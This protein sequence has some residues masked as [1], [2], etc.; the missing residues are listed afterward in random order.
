MSQIRR[1]RYH[2][3][4]EE[5]LSN[6]FTANFMKTRGIVRRFKRKR[7]TDLLN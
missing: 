2:D 6:N 5:H 3:R 7:S 4:L 1:Q